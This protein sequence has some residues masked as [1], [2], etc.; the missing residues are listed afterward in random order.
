[1]I[2]DEVT[3]T[4]SDSADPLRALRAVSALRR[5]ADQ[6]ENQQVEEALRRGHTWQDIAGALGVTRQAAHK[7]H[8]RRISPEL[9]ERNTR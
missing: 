3:R 2:P 8:A 6:L 5:L 4:A 9:R 7:K 1:M